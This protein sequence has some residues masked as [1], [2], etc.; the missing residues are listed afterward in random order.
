MSADGLVAIPLSD[1]ESEV[2][3]GRPAIGLSNLPVLRADP[4]L[5]IQEDSISCLVCGGVFR[6]LTN[7]H[8]RSHGTTA[9]EYKLHFGYNRGRP[10]MCRAL[11]R[12]YAERARRAGLAARIRRR[13]I[14]VEPELRR[15]GGAR[16]ISLEETLTRRDARRRDIARRAA[17][18]AALA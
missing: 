18:K 1:V 8:L 11:A 9:G 7:T 13:P 5:A 14:L 10:L 6:Q 3:V 12:L 17:V 16:A 15:R 2:R 4:R